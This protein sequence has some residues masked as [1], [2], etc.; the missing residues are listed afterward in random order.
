MLSVLAYQPTNIPGVLNT[1]CPIVRAPTACEHLQV[2]VSSARAWACN[3]WPMA[4]LMLLEASRVPNSVCLPL[5]K[6]LQSTYH[7]MLNSDTTKITGP[8]ITH[9]ASSGSGHKDQAVSGLALLL[10]EAVQKSVQ[11][12]AWTELAFCLDAA[13]EL[14]RVDTGVTAAC[15][16]MYGWNNSEFLGLIVG[17]TAQQFRDLCAILVWISNVIA[18]WSVEA[19]YQN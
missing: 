9:I 18:A 13:C 19:F 16:H 4:K 5:W 12:D 10:P 14:M 8:E 11:R 3:Q 7:S 17:Q 15:T 1:S 6:M 2:V